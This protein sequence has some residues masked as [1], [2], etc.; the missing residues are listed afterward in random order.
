MPVLPLIAQRLHHQ[1][2][3]KPA[4]GGPEE[5]VRRL[6]VVQAQDFA[7]AKFAI[8]LRL[9]YAATDDDIEQAIAG[10]QIIRSWSLRGT[11]H[12][13]A[14]G[15][16]H[17][18][19]SLAGPR[20]SSLYASHYRKLG[21]EGATLKRGYRLMIRALEG[22][23]QLT[24]PELKELL[25]QNGISTQELRLNFLLLKAALEG[26]ICLGTRRGKAFTYTLLDEWIP[27]NR[28]CPSGEEALSRLAERYFTSHG[29]ATLRDFIWWSGLT[30]ADAKLALEAAK[31]LLSAIQQDGQQYWRPGEATQM[32][33]LRPAA[34]LLP[35]FDE[36]LVGYKDRS[37]VLDARYVPRVM[38]TGNGL[39]SPVLVIHGRVAGTWKRTVRKS[40]VVIS[41]APFQPL[42]KLQARQANT[43]AKAFGAYLGL[44]ATVL[45]ENAS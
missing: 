21:L 28:D 26:I 39:F 16:I 5:V 15:D 2:I 32:A 37:A 42:S 30:V 45:W 19:L 9:P 7:A 3:A 40:E 6:G 36:Y 33:A 1:L 12:F 44:P 43:A 11:L 38:G 22:G 41:L 29:P 14:P 25:E 13:M 24:R 35:S 31:P 17:W 4:N 23:H 8:A 18:L 10:K 34:Q 27:Q 20:L